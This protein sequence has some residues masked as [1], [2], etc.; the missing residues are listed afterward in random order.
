MNN[1]CRYSARNTNNLASNNAF[2]NALP[3]NTLNNTNNDNNTQ[4]CSNGCTNDGLL[5]VL[6]SCIGRRCSCEFDTSDGL[7]TR[8]GLL[9]RVGNDYILLRSLNNN[10]LMYCSTCDLMFI[11]IMC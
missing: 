10:R 3:T 5:D 4:A 2:N 6:C 8:T 11:S 7:E 1:C 9:E